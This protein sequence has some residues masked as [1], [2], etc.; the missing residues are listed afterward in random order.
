[1][2]FSVAFGV[3][4][5]CFGFWLSKLECVLFKE[6]KIFIAM[7]WCIVDIFR[8]QKKSARS[9]RSFQFSSLSSSTSSFCFFPF[10]L[11]VVL[12]NMQVDSKTP[13]TV[14]LAPLLLYRYIH[15]T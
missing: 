10:R 2:A 5:V 14:V 3:C 15:H 4:F 11:A 8:Y 6:R 1:V 9:V 12:E 13:C 7:F